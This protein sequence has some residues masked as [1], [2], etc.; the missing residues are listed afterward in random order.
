MNFDLDNENYTKED[1]MEIFNLDKD[2]NITADKLNNKYKNLLKDIKN[3]NLN[4]E[5]LNKIKIFLL[6]FINNTNI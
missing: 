6:L 2:M 1:Y 4:H 5:D 3:E